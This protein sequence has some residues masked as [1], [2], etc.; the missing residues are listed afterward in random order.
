M[1]SY[2]EIHEDHLD[3]SWIS[4]LDPGIRILC[5]LSFLVFV[6]LA[7]GFLALLVLAFSIA[8]FGLFSRCSP[9]SVLR[10]LKP[11]LWLVVVTFFLNLFLTP[12]RVLLKSWGLT[13]TYDGLVRGGLLSLKLVF[14]ISVAHILLLTTPANELT[15]GLVRLLSPLR[16]LRVPVSEIGV[17]STL[18]LRLIPGI[19]E[20]A[21]RIFS[22]QR[23]R[24]AFGRGLVAKARGTLPMVAPLLSSCLQRGERLSRALQS[25]GYRPEV[26]ST[27]RGVSLGDYLTLGAVWL[28]GFLSMWVGLGVG[29]H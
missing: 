17:V 14:M 7:K 19:R 3:R 25:R 12:G 15:D 21:T 4:R 27:S 29:R 26:R 24:G 1:I 18:T 23:A 13:L 20:E 10:T 28:I 22:A 9:G 5:A 6:L 11:F 16:L 8:L 2:G